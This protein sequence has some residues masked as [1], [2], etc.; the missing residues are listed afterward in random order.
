[1]GMAT[2]TLSDAAARYD[3]TEDVIRAWH[4]AG[5]ITAVRVGRRGAAWEFDET[6]LDREVAQLPRCVH[7]RCDRPVAAPGASC[8]EHR[9]ADSAKA[10]SRAEQAQVARR[11]KLE[12]RLTQ[13]VAEQAAE[14]RAHQAGR[15]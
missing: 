13:R 3:A 4:R 10:R 12:A 2:L 9:R 1:M 14:F 11:Q 15:L 8:H 5:L 7:A 6:V